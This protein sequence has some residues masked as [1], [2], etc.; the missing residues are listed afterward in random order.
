MRLQGHEDV[1]SNADDVTEKIKP[2]SLAAAVRQELERLILTGELPAGTRINEFRLAERLGVSRGPVR[3]ACR[4]LEQIGL[5]ESI[6]NR[7]AF[8]RKI[9]LDDALDIMEIRQALVALAAPRVVKNITTEEIEHLSQLI[10]KMEVEVN[11]SNIEGYYPLNLE[12]H[13]QIIRAAKA[14]RL[15]EIYLGLDRELALYRRTALDFD[16][17]MADS[18]REHKAILRAIKARDIQRCTDTMVNHVGSGQQRIVKVASAVV[19]G[20]NADIV[21]R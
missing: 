13:E 14:K 17:G 7:G 3:E 18:L 6:Q 20:A 5:V 15:T 16:Y 21:E 19:Q 1:L 8:V 9:D 11:L 12:F 10:V 4:R 2:Y